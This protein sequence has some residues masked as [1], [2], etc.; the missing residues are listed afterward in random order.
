MSRSLA[1]AILLFL[2]IGTHFSVVASQQAHHSH[3]QLH[4]RG[5]EIENGQNSALKT[6]EEALEALRIANKLRVEN[7]QF[8]K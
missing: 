4:E 1:L 7:S 3:H 8:N 5:R 2:L 6:V